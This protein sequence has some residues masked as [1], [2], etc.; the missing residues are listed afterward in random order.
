MLILSRRINE[1]LILTLED[2]RRIEVAIVDIRGDKVRVGVQ[3]D[4]SISIHRSEVQ[5]EID[6]TNHLKRGEES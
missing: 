5:E 6:A 1:S 4:G 2:G 3:A